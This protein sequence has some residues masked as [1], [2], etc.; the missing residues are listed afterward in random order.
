MIAMKTVFSKLDFPEAPGGDRYE[1]PDAKTDFSINKTG[2]YVIKIVA[3]AKNAKQNKSTDDDDLRIALN[4]FHFGKYEKRKDKVSWKGFGTSAAWDGASLKGGTKTIYYFAE[5]DEGEHIVQF[6]A[7]GKPEI[8]SLE[9]F[10]MQSLHFELNDLIPEENINSNKKGIPWLSFVFLGSRLKSLLVH[11]EVKSAKEKGTTDGDNL[12]IVVNGKILQ[13]P[14]MPSS[15]KYQNFYFSGDVKQ[16]SVLSIGADELTNPLALENSLEFWYDNQP[17]ILNLQID[18]HD[19]SAFLDEYKELELEEII[20]FRAW[21]AIKIFKIIFKPYSAKFLQHSLDSNPSTLIFKANHPIV[22]KIKADPAYQK[23]IDKI[24]VKL[25]KGQL[26]GEIWPKE[27]INF[28]TW[29]FDTALH[30]IK[31]IEYSAK[32]NKNDLYIVKIKLFDVYDFQRTDVPFSLFNMLAY[33][34]QLFINA[35]DLGENLEIIKNFEIQINLNH[36]LWLSVP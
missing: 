30:G 35:L 8:I 3:K 18:Y 19:S 12:K 28:T 15:K 36:I 34:K 23:I 4:S 22:S 13:N 9:V 17:K 29:D 33:S 25:S 16:I 26:E 10:E 14:Q 1:W 2:L 21:I 31:K 11:A 27:Q 20:R 7:D 6:F 5:L 32:K 24:S